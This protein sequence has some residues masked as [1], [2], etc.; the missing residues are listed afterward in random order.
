MWTSYLLRL[1]GKC[2]SPKI[3]SKTQPFLSVAL[4]KLIMPVTFVY[5]SNTRIEDILFDV[6]D[7]KFPYNAVIGRV[8]LNAFEAVLHS[9]YLC[10]KIPIN[11]GIISVYGSQ[12]AARKT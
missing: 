10:M 3:N 7:M 9:L 5:V 2:R 6:V 8:T 11:Q 1:S 4:G 12:E